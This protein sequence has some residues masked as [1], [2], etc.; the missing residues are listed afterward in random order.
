MLDARQIS[1][2]IKGRK[3][4]EQQKEKLLWLI[5]TVVRGS[6]RTRTKGIDQGN[7]YSPTCLNA[8]LHY[9][10]DQPLIGIIS[11]PLYW[12]RYADNLCY[13]A[14]S[15]P[16]DR[17]ILR[18]AR[19]LL[20]PFGLS[21]K[22]EDGVQNLG[23]GKEVSLLGFTLRREGKR[24]VYSLGKKALDQLAQNLSLTHAA[25]HPTEST[26]LTLLGWVESAGAAFENGAIVIPKILRLA[27]DLGF[28]ELASPEELRRHWEIAWGRWQK[29]RERSY[30]RLQS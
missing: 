18:K 26:K 19:R 23:K 16:E 12:F 13:L 1:E 10:L 22:G 8:V 9:R 6:N 7:P 2:G 3:E 11:S 27:A 24:V 4:A 20:R 14:G 15:V 28:R 25:A 5:E 21:L 30:R 17:L 29:I